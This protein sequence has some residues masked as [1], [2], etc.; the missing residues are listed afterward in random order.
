MYA[1]DYTPYKLKKYF[2]S[3][4]EADIWSRLCSNPKAINLIDKKMETNP[5]LM[6][7]EYLFL[8]KNVYK[9]ITKEGNILNDFFN[10]KDI[11]PYLYNDISLCLG[12]TDYELRKNI[13]YYANEKSIKYIYE[14]NLAE[15]LLDYNELKYNIYIGELYNPNFTKE[16]QDIINE[17]KKNKSS[18]SISIYINLTHKKLYSLNKSRRDK[19]TDEL[20]KNKK[21]TLDFFFDDDSDLTDEIL[22][23]HIKN[24]IIKKGK[25]F[26]FDLLIYPYFVKF[27]TFSNIERI[28]DLYIEHKLLTSENICQNP[29]AI[30]FIEKNFKRMAEIDTSGYG[31][32]ELGS[33]PYIDYLIQTQKL[34]D[35]NIDHIFRNLAGNN[36]N[37]CND[38]DLKSILNMIPKKYF[39]Q[40]NREFRNRE[41]LK[42]G[43]MYPITD[44]IKKLGTE[45]N[46]LINNNQSLD[47]F[48]L[49]NENPLLS[50]QLLFSILT[51][52]Y[53]TFSWFK[54]S[55]FTRDHDNYRSD[56]LCFRN[57]EI[58]EIDYQEIA[59]LIE[60]FKEELIQKCFHPKRLVYYLEKYNYDIGC[61]EFNSL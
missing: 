31:I 15:K 1:F 30:R 3:F 14:K 18:S 29:R 35:K 23:Y 47:L 26:I 20:D 11:C 44:G 37:I 36:K 54:S 42:F 56:Y 21:Y 6:N 41:R 13:S 2:R 59:K 55:S 33:N 9:L 57:P 49:Y 39:N 28:C 16:E 50:H 40:Y 27:L 53:K 7:Y 51:N 10:N 45:L 32:S 22:E 43:Y 5:E 38:E 8:N 34:S 17:M 24:K 46:K 12:G 4:H 61:D 60:P 48:S 19:I 25:N 52:N 58:Y